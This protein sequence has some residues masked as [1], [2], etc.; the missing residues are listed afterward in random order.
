MVVYIFIWKYTNYIQMIRYSYVSQFKYVY[1]VIVQNIYFFLFIYFLNV[2]S[3]RTFHVLSIDVLPL[4]IKIST[5][6]LEMLMRQMIFPLEIHATS[7]L[8]INSLLTLEVCCYYKVIAFYF[9]LICTL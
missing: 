6:F 2:D 8:E 3:K 7:S 1:I 9:G 5:C 4:A